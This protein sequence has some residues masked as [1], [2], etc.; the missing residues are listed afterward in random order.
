[1][2]LCLLSGQLSI[3]PD[4]EQV[5]RRLFS[6]PSW[7][8]KCLIGA[9]LMAVPILHFA[10]FGY[11]AQVVRQAVQGEAFDL[12]EWDD[13]RFLFVRGFFYFVILAGVAGG[14]LLAAVVVSIPFQRWLGLVAYVPFI[15]AV[16]LAAPL[17]GAAWYRFERTGLLQEAFRLPALLLLLREAGPGLVLPTLAFLGLLFAGIPVFPLAFFL[18]GILVFFFYAAAFYRAEDNRRVQAET[19]F[20]VL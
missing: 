15:P 10:A 1:M 19:A 4:F 12:P 8:L 17:T 9:L 7:M 16:V 2:S 18:G 5:C 13:W 20:S 6:D 3:M 11:L 14:L